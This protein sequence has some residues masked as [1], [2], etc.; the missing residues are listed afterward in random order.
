MVASLCKNGLRDLRGGGGGAK[1]GAWPVDELAAYLPQDRV[2]ALAL[3]GE[4]PEVCGGAVLFA[5]LSGFT[6]RP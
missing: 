4:L 5:D 6:P 2:R 1:H 3:G